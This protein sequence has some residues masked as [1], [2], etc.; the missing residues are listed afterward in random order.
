MIGEELSFHLV[1]EKELVAQ[2]KGEWRLRMQEMFKSK[3][4][5]YGMVH[6]KCLEVHHA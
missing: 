3:D 5:R 4:I 1:L 6:Q 2:K